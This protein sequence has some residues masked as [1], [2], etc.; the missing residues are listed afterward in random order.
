MWG[1]GELNVGGSGHCFERGLVSQPS[2]THEAVAVVLGKER[3][4]G[5]GNGGNAGVLLLIPPL[6]PISLSYSR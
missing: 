6:P 2:S 1:C 4:W 3:R 5:R